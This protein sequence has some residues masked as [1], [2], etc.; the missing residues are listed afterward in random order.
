MQQAY[1][2]SVK[3]SFVYKHNMPWNVALKNFTQR[4][5]VTR[6][7]ISITL[8]S[9]HYNGLALVGMISWLELAG[10]GEENYYSNEEQ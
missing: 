2:Q 9:D 7:S 8:A 5:L 3:Y 1:N 4:T 6:I 10:L